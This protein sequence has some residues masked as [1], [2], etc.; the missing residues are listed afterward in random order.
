VLERGTWSR[1]STAGHGEFAADWVEGKAG[2]DSLVC[3]RQG[4][5]SGRAWRIE[6]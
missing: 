1:L 4:C 6:R 3:L 5:K 2:Q